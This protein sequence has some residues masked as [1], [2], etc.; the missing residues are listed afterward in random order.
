MIMQHTHTQTHTRVHL[1]PR[2]FTLACIH[3]IA[4]YQYFSIVLFLAPEQFKQNV[5]V[6]SINSTHALIRWLPFPDNLWNT[7]DN[8]SRVY[9]IFIK[10]ISF[11]KFWNE[12]VIE[13]LATHPSGEIV[14]GPLE[15]DRTYAIQIAAMN[16]KG[17]GV[18]SK[19]LCIR[20]DEG[21]MY[22]NDIVE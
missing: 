17:V 21:G 16:N 12:S 8:S 4:V 10:E 14:V 1:C 19:E 5:T 22:S 13:L 11:P 9:K 18:K 20:M 2:K 15:E 3:A 6:S 7:G